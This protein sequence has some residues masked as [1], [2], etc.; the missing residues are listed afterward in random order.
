MSKKATEAQIKKFNA[1]KGDQSYKALGEKLLISP[2][3]LERFAEG[4]QFQDETAFEKIAAW[5]D[6]DNP[7]PPVG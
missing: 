3:L 2:E 5:A 4:Q 1:R 6:G 7:Q